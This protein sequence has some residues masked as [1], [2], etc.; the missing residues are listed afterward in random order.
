MNLMNLYESFKMRKYRVNAF[1]NSK[2]FIEY[3]ND[4]DDII[5]KLLK[6]IIQIKSVKC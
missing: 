6:Y 3:S 1:N 5:I 2:A 4:M